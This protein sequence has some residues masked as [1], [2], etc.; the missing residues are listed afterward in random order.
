[1]SHE[2]RL[3]ALNL[4]LPPPV[5]PM[6]SYTPIVTVGKMVYVSGHGPVGPDGSSVKGRLGADLD[7][8]AGYEAGQRTGLAMLATLKDKFG[9]LDAIRR[10]VKTNGFV[11]STPEFIDH[12]AV[13][14]GFSELM[15][16]VFGAEAGIGA[17]SSLGIASL[18]A[19]WAVEIEAIFE[20][21]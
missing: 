9:S 18:P 2:A 4:P 6:G 13:I 10:I 21:E 14:N 17:R 20:L 8:A 12:P 5:K 3:Q 19:G 1:M 11:N 16:D 7:K 15:R